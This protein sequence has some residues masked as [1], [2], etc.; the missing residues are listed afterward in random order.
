VAQQR[1]VDG[2]IGQVDE[3]LSLRFAHAE[4]VNPKI[5]QFVDDLKAQ[6]LVNLRDVL[7]KGKAWGAEKRMV[8][9]VLCGDDLDKRYALLNTSGQYS[10]MHEVITSLAESEK[11]ENAVHIGNMRELYEAIDPSIS[12]LIELAE[13]WIWWDLPDAV[14]IQAH[15]AQVIRI[16]RLAQ[17]EITDQVTDYYRQALGLAPGEPVARDAM[18]QCE[19]RRL[20]RLVTEFELRRRDDLAHT[21]V[22]KRDILNS[23][24]VD[25]IVEDLS[26]EIQALARLEKTET[27][28]ETII[29]HFARKLATDPAHV[30]R[31]HILDWQ[32]EHIARLKQQVLT[33]LHTGQVLGPPQNYK[34]QQLARMK[35][36]TQEITHQMPEVISEPAPAPA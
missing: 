20:Q 5:G 19:F 26:V 10:I 36:E 21:E 22:L 33:A 30:G 25:Q 14:N 24:G 12:S 1:R 29:A 18:L 28:D 7:T 6:L 23:G 11:G 2:I 8:A 3:Y 32:R 9:D 4:R 31:Q 34:V 27:F 16:K 17:M 13:T 15:Q 35:E